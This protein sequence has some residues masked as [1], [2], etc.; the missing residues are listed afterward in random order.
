MPGP[1]DQRLWRY[2]RASRG[3]LAAVVLLGLV[4][5]AA[6][7][8][9]AGAAAT[10]LVRLA[11]DPHVRTLGAQSRLLE[12]AAAAACA[13]AAV[14][15]VRS[16]IE[17][18]A[19]E[20]VVSQLR[21]AALAA[22]GTLAVT[23]G[24]GALDPAAASAA[25]S[26]AA[27]DPAHDPT[28]AHDPASDA[29]LRTVV[30]RGL[31]DLPPYLTGYLPALALS[32]TAVPVLIVAIAV[33]DPLS[34][35]II[36]GTLP[37]LPVFMVLVGLLTRDRT[38][39]RLEAMSRLSAQLLDL[40]AGLPTLRA[41][42]RERGP[43][44]RVRELGERNASETMASLRVAF[45]SSMVLELLATL[46][47]ALVAVSIGLR[48]V[49]GGMGLA[50]GV[51]ALI[52]APE[53]YL[54]LRAVGAQFHAAEQGVASSS[55]VFALLDAAAAREPRVPVAAGS[56]SLRVRDLTVAGRDGAAPCAL[57]AHFPPGEVT[58]V[59][60][61][62]GAGKSTLLAVLLGLVAP[63]SG[64]A[65]VVDWDRVAWC[66]QHPVVPPGSI[67]DAFLLL[68]APPVDASES[69]QACA[70]TGFDEV[71]ADH[72]WDKQIGTG[73]VGLSAGQRQRLALA[74]TLARSAAQ[75]GPRVLLLD[76]PTAHLDR[77]LE[78]RVLVELRRRAAAGDTVVVVA[79]HA[80]VLAAADT[81]VE[82]SARRAAYA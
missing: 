20:R 14:A 58:V 51:F 73:G 40:V 39:R 8:V 22:V 63:T 66:P 54:P 67:E 29:D 65:D 31:D 18:R 25:A 81:V 15:Y 70:A 16:R 57:T 12:C 44:A 30:T 28:P 52:L 62:N 53:V 75:P 34:A 2:A 5:T 1:V 38:R 27:D 50:A 37:L 68:G 13:R 21:S 69:V 4:G 56:G 46:C 48:L 72:G 43:A 79:H 59:T 55:R 49:F 19:A 41:L 71:V 3:L 47:V 33:A 32:A 82:V 76:E 9:L 80:P 6:T 74:R 42:G 45:L 26:A 61:P 35:A 23:G 78:A 7:I 10:V 17:H 36:V 64:T 11:A 60:G 24:P 77:D